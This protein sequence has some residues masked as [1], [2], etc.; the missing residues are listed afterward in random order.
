MSDIQI[1][2]VSSSVL[3][4]INHPPHYTSGGIE[5][6]DYIDAKF[7]KEQLKGFLLGNIIKYISRHPHKGGLSDL[8]KANWYLDKLI[9]ITEEQTIAMSDKR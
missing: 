9:K 2:S 7:T 5:V 3:D 4:L 8:K 1:E 6:I